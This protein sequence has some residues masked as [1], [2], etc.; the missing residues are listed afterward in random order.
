M[1]NSASGRSVHVH[2]SRSAD[3][4]GSSRSGSIV[5]EANEGGNAV[6]RLGRQRKS[7]RAG[8]EH[9]GAASAT[10]ASENGIVLPGR[11]HRPARTGLFYLGGSERL[12]R[13]RSAQAIKCYQIQTF[14]GAMRDM[15]RIRFQLPSW[16]PPG[17]EDPCLLRNSMAHKHRR[18]NRLESV[19][20]AHGRKRPRPESTTEIKSVVQPRKAPTHMR[21]DSCVS[22]RAP[23]GTATTSGSD[24]G[25]EHAAC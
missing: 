4:G 3:A 15:L 18:V 14:A 19:A 6:Q 23:F 16:T 11:A 17:A 9:T 10:Q 7:V 12:R 2:R 20:P 25:A 13:R 22:T 21:R 5:I 24:A 8:Q 1:R